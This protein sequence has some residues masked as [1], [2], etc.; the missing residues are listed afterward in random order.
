MQGLIDDIVQISEISY[1]LMRNIDQVNKIMVHMPKDAASKVQGDGN[2]SRKSNL[3]QVL[4]EK[5]D[6]IRTLTSQLH[7]QEEIDQKI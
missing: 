2:Q 5:D 7:Q 4:K 1:V 6:Q 3:I